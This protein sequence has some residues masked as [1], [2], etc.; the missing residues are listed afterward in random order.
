[1]IVSILNKDAGFYSMFFFTLNHFCYA[2]KHQKKFVLDTSKWMYKS[3]EGWT[4]Y[5]LSP[6]FEGD[7][8]PYEKCTVHRHNHL[9][10]DYNMW[11]YREA[12]L[13]FLYRYNYATKHRIEETKKHLGIVHGEYDAIY[14]RHG[15]K[16]CSESVVIPTERYVDWLLLKNPNC[17]K[18]FVQTDDYNV[19]L[20]VK[21]YLIE[22]G[23]L[24]IDAFTLC[25]EHTK[26]FVTHDKYFKELEEALE[27]NKNNKNYLSE[28]Y[29][30]IKRSKPVERMNPEEI[31]EHTMNL[32][33]SVDISMHSKYCILD[34][35]SNVARFISIVHDNNRNLFD[36]R[37]PQENINMDWTMCPAYW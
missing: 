4:D 3:W 37:Y 18:I 20:T 10:G 2:K 11:E 21:N 27:K 15:D 8:T 19:Y 31:Y 13:K 5:F 26:G 9:T 22:I 36:V 17:K 6:Y 14:I 34:N 24:E 25:E 16:L 33:I 32:I 30:D 35:Q 23:R 1:M 29:D 12:A 28:I 7:E